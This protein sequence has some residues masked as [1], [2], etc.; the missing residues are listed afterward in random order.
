VV[1]AH[2]FSER[3]SDT[4]AVWDGEH[5][6]RS[7]YRFGRDA[8][9]EVR[10]TECTA[11]AA[12]AESARNLRSG[13]L[14]IPLRITPQSVHILC[15]G[16]EY[17]LAALAVRRIGEKRIEY[18]DTA[19]SWGCVRAEETEEFLRFA[20][21]DALPPY[22]GITLTLTARKIPERSRVEWSAEVGNASDAYSLMWCGYPRLVY[23]GTG[24]CDLFVPEH[25]G[26]VRGEFSR[27]DAF[28]AG[29]YPAGFQYTLPY[30]A[31]YA[32]DGGGIYCGFHDESGAMKD[33][34]ASS[35]GEGRVSLWGKWHAENAGLP[36]NGAVLPGTAVWQMLDGDWFD[37]ADIYREF[38]LQCGWMPAASENG[39]ESIPEWMR[40][41]PF[42]IMDW[43]PNESD[44]D[45]P[46]PVSIRPQDGEVRE[47][48]WYRLPI[49]LRQRLG[50]PIGYHVYNWHKIPFNNDFPHFFPVKKAFRE[51]LRE[52][53]AEGVRVMP[54]INALLWDTRDR[55]CE[56]WRFTKEAHAGAAKFEDGTVITLT[57]GQ[58]EADGKP[59]QLA[60]MCPS[61]PMWRQKLK[62][63]VTTL[64]GDYG[65]DGVY[66]DQIAT[67]LP[68]RCMDPAH[69]HPLGGGSWWQKE[70]RALMKELY[71][72]KPADGVYTSE[73][74]AEV[75]ANDM[76]GLLGWSWVAAEADVPAFQRIYGGRVP[77]FGR[78]ANGYMKPETVHW[79]YQ[80]A[81]AFVN[82]EQMGWINS[83]FVR[84]E[85][86]FAFASQLIR[87]RYAHREFFRGA[88]VM[89]PPQS[90]A[91]EELKFSCGVAMGCPGV[92]HRPYLCT[93]ALENG[94][95]RMLFAVNLAEREITDRVRICEKEYRLCLD[96]AVR[97]GDGTAE[98]EGDV[99]T[100]TLPAGGMIVLEWQK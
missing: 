58:Y 39:K 9:E 43:M 55:G 77:V 12:E 96:A 14:Q 87:F 91:P 99:L 73:G 83:D 98:K 17:P 81:K 57:Y 60:P 71:A 20:F 40:D 15:A 95:K 41:I 31:L 78:N 35:D 33:M 24:A 70:Y 85:N 23:R 62:E 80:L 94:E 97:T 13:K 65:V 86:R 49:L 74:N 48:D 36:R 66:L 5:P 3:V 34:Q 100:F 25:G 69:G 64:F 26:S 37:A 93:G 59:V 88:R 76:D 32:A 46:V 72:V 53:Q 6:R 22:G 21:T 63:I 7:R 2:Y 92:L 52:L 47:D 56:D 8:A 18:M 82:G 38:A 75:Y 29:T 4:P 19:V 30:Y 27:T 79:K 50:T 67:K 54:Y 89:R 68:V 45:G 11:S 42:W 16:R 61:V 10:E 44:A 1:D 90:L 51:G 84:D 28:A